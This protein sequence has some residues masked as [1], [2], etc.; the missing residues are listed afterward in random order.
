VH[1]IAYGLCR[2]GRDVY[3]LLSDIYLAFGFY[4]QRH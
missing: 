2:M 4:N 3:R 1:L